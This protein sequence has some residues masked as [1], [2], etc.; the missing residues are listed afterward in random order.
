MSIPSLF[1]MVVVASVVASSG[2]VDL[3]GPMGDA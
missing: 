1:F 2:G 3:A